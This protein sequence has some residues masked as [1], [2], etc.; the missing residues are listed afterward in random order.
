MCVSISFI[1]SV[2]IN[3]YNYYYFCIVLGHICEDGRAVP[4]YLT[5]LLPRVAHEEVHM[6]QR[7][8]HSGPP[9]MFV[10]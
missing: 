8:A 9:I 3:I 10:E 2:H 6:A 1:S 7:Q 4:A 5:Q